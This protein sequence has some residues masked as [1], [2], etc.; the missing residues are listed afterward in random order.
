MIEL[1][2]RLLR[3]NEPGPPCAGCLRRISMTLALVA[4]WVK[5]AYNQP[6][7]WGSVAD[8]MNPAA[9]ATFS[10]DDFD[11]PQTRYFSLGVGTTFLGYSG[12]TASDPQPTYFFF[13]S[14]LTG[15]VFQGMILDSSTTSMNSAALSEGK[16]FMLMP[17]KFSSTLARQITMQYDPISDT[18]S[19]TSITQFSS[20][21]AIEGMTAA[22]Q[23]NTNFFM[24]KTQDSTLRKW[25][26]STGFSPAFATVLYNNCKWLQTYQST[27]LVY[28]STNT[29]IQFVSQSDMTIV[30]T[31]SGTL[32]GD[33]Y[34]VD[35]TNS[36]KM[37]IVS[38]P[39][40]HLLSYV[41]IGSFSS[42]STIVSRT[43]PAALKSE[44]ALMGVF[45]I[46]GIFETDTTFN[47]Y[48]KNNLSTVPIDLWTP[49]IISGGA[50][51]MEMTFK[52]GRSTNG[53]FFPIHLLGRT[54]RINFHS[55]YIYMDYC[56]RDSNNQCISCPEG[57]YKIPSGN[58]C[59][60]TFIEEG[61]DVSGC[62]V[63]NCIE[64]KADSKICTKC[65]QLPFKLYLFNNLCVP[66]AV[67]GYGPS[68]D[69]LVPCADELCIDCS[70]SS[71]VCFSCNK[72]AESA[73]FEQSCITK[74]EMKERKMGLTQD[75]AE[76][77][78]CAIPQCLDCVEDY[79]KCKLCDSSNGYLASAD[80]AACQDT[81]V[82]LQQS[83]I[84][85]TY[86]SETST[87][88]M[89][90]RG[91][92]KQ[93]VT[94][95]Y[96]SISLQD[97]ADFRVPVNCS[98]PDSDVLI[99]IREVG[100]DYIL[101]S[102][103]TPLQV[104]EGSANFSLQ[105]GKIITSTSGSLIIG[106]P[107]TAES[108]NFRSFVLGFT[109]SSAAFVNSVLDVSRAPLMIITAIARSPS[110]TSPNYVF[111]QQLVMAVLEG[112]FLLYADSILF[113]TIKYIKGIPPM[114]NLF[115][116]LGDDTDYCRLPPRYTLL[117][118]NCSF[119]LNMGAPFLGFIFIFVLT[120]LVTFVH[121]KLK[122][123]TALV[124][125]QSTAIKDSTSFK[126]LS[127]R[128]MS[129]K[130]FQLGSSTSV[131]VS[132]RLSAK[133]IRVQ[134]SPWLDLLANLR[135]DFFINNLESCLAEL[136]LFAFI[137][138]TKDPQITVVKTGWMVSFLVCWLLIFLFV[139]TLRG[140]IWIM[141][142]SSTNSSAGQTIG[143]IVDLETAD[144]PALVKRYE[145]LCCPTGVIYYVQP[146]ADYIRAALT[147]LAVINFRTMPAL[148][149]STVIGIQLLFMINYVVF[150]S[151]KSKK[152]M[153]LTVWIESQFFMYMI[154]KLVVLYET[155][156]HRVQNVYGLIMAVLLVSTQIT[157]AI[158]GLYS[159]MITV[160]EIIKSRS[161]ISKLKDKDSAAFTRNTTSRT[162]GEPGQAAA[163]T[164]SLNLN[165]SKNLS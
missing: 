13:S 8:S 61:T 113:N 80:G 92:I 104:I 18:Y 23:D 155:D 3:H 129:V 34:K 36:T 57:F 73:L 11:K 152:D 51:L 143:K 98:S 12:M 95:D 52:Q 74:T 84:L 58:D 48:Y 123:K 59:F 77:K 163:G 101:F 66:S 142:K 136:F 63:Q 20:A 86:D 50:I 44:V 64:C 41:D 78:P 42:Y 160:Y 106:F 144:Y 110:A 151:V 134:S 31:L 102:L 133:N 97:A 14:K 108:I 120:L 21:F 118:L 158:A 121:K 60:P 100:T 114:P 138:L 47:L 111:S 112:P 107:T 153:W 67:P 135:T 38:N 76:A 49:Q 5:Q 124:T 62:Q 24:L 22:S 68:G 4:I 32:R 27:V 99:R 43:F 35:N 15:P 69:T 10:T 115:T 137:N 159:L 122:E 46:I 117:E 72:Q 116:Y 16:L 93:D 9:N 6:L 53:L 33:F 94:D 1:D 150:Y 29:V 88:R 128:I 90:F 147:A 85:T 91:P 40:P 132:S 89:Q 127:S 105:A 156:S 141:R 65:A 17:G 164:D 81:T 75:G 37:Y 79:T 71:E 131:T 19:A 39:N 146:V 130:R 157:T 139:T 103:T 70:Q 30:N 83:R 56:T 119:V 109:V 28:G 26:P 54:T 45:Q 55:Y 161:S 25:D 2:M 82:G 96:F 126:P 149:I 145:D 125:A 154:L 165:D 87:I 7:L 148:Q 140:A 162:E